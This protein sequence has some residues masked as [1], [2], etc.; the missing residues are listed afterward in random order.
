MNSYELTVAWIGPFRRG[1]RI[2]VDTKGT[3]RS[4]SGAFNDEAMLCDID[5]HKSASLVI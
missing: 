5:I 4:G 2:L 1:D 3:D